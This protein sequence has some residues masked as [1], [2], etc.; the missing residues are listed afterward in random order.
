MACDIDAD[1]IRVNCYDKCL[2]TLL[3]VTQT[4]SVWIHS[5]N[6]LRERINMSR[7]HRVRRVLLRAVSLGVFVACA[8]IPN[9]AAAQNNEGLAVIPLNITNNVTSTPPLFAYIVGQ[10]GAPSA[11]LPAGTAVY[12]TDMQGDVAITPSIPATA[13]MSLGLDVGIGTS[14]SMMLPQLTGM[15]IYLSLGNGL[16][17][18]NNDMGTQPSA[19][20]GWCGVP[21]TGNTMNDANFNTIFDWAELTWGPKI[22]G[23]GHETNLGGG[24]TQVE[25]F[26]L[27]LYLT[28][29][30]TNPAGM[31]SI[32]VN[33]GFTQKRPTI[34]NAYA[35]LG[36]PWTSLLLTNSSGTRVRVISPY[37]GIGMGV[38]PANE[39]APYI[40]QVWGSS[41]L[42]VHAST[43]CVQDGGLLHSF[44]AQNIGGNMVFSTTGIVVQFPPPS[45][46]TVYTNGIAA[47]ASVP[48]TPIP[49]LAPCLA[50]VVAAKLGGALVRTVVLANPDLDACMVN[51]FYLNAPVQQYA[52]LFHQFGVGNLAYPFGYD[53]TCN[54]SSYI[55]VDNPTAVDITISGVTP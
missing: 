39:L 46:F 37:N 19:P 13:P 38:F 6:K 40:S 33:A 42:L 16:L 20:C 29:A 51:Q 31:D 52:Q 45:T 12:V 15:R 30:G 26:G 9:L 1:V 25:M 23:P 11:T 41:T 27:P 48:E 34:M 2:E 54:Q 55:T 36:S 50:G 53:D 47:S 8:S 24:V 7:Y 14:I 18:Q 44:V 32:T 22:A 17:V 49:G 4:K 21:P 10:L 3:T 35:A 28:L 43:A 5:A